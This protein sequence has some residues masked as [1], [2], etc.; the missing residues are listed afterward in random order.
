MLEAAGEEERE[1]AGQM[2]EEFLGENLP[3]TDFTAAKP[4]SGT[5]A[6]CVRLVNP[7]EVSQPLC[8]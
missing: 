7:I 5:W 2:A 3:D 4:G 8:K 6:S 1:A